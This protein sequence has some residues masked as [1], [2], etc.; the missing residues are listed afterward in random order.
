MSHDY[1]I[2]YCTRLFFSH[3]LRSDITEE[4]KRN[5]EKNVLI[6]NLEMVIGNPVGKNSVRKDQE[7]SV[8]INIK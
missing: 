7:T 1:D 2:R 5:K 4:N 3:N 8:N 6:N